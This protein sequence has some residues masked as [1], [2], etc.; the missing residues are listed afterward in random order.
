MGFIWDLMGSPSEKWWFFFLWNMGISWNWWL[1][2]MIAK[3]VSITP[4]SLWFTQITIVF[5]GV[6]NQ[7]TFNATLGVPPCGNPGKTLRRSRMMKMRGSCESYISKG[8]WTKDAIR[9]Y[10]NIKK[11]LIPLL[12]SGSWRRT[13]MILQLLWKMILPQGGA[14]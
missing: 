9:L 3:L 14:P 7:E 2:T 6:I 10:I 13:N 1:M 5:M 8:I 11:I 4:P 12:R